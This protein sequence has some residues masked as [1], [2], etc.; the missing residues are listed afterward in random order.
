MGTRDTNQADR[1]AR[2]AEIRQD[3]AMCKTAGLIAV[4]SDLREMARHA[5]WLVAQLEAVTAR[6][7]A[8]REAGQTLRDAFPDQSWQHSTQAADAADAWDEAVAS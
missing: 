6:E 4:G 7:K 5:S 8:L 2:L 3:I 1:E